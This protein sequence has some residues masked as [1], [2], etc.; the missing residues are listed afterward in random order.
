LTPGSI[1]TIGSTINR[2]NICSDPFRAVRP[3][4]VVLKS[5]TDQWRTPAVG[6]EAPKSVKCLG[7]LE[8]RELEI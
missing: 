8:M 5:N 1:C 4:G 2:P 3:S 7:L 6:A